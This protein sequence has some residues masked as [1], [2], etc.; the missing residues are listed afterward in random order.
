MQDIL[1]EDLEV[2]K[3]PLFGIFANIFVVVTAAISVD[4]VRVA[5]RLLPGGRTTG[6]GSY[7]GCGTSGPGFTFRRLELG[8]S[9]R[10]KR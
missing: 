10:R 9:G 2:N 8:M 7:I 4:S 3:H 6:E 5:F 1:H